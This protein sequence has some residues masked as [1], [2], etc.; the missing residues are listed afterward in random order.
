MALKSEWE[1]AGG[2]GIWLTY[3]SYLEKGLDRQKKV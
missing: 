2:N 3:Y 1:I